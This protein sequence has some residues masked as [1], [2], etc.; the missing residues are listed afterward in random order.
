MN[1]ATIAELSIR[2]KVTPSKKDSGRRL[3]HNSAAPGA[4]R[5]VQPAANLMCTSECQQPSSRL[6]GSRGAKLDQQAP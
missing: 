4:T 2:L 3:S 5:P 1:R 6:A